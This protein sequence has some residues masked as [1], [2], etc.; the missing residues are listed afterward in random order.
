MASLLVELCSSHIE[1]M[2]IFGEGGFPLAM[3]K[4]SALNKYLFKSK[5]LASYAVLR[6]EKKLFTHKTISELL[7]K[8]F[9]VALMA[10]I[11]VSL[12]FLF[13]GCCVLHE[14]LSRI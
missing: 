10:L 8:S 6:K 7:M 9:N 3:T 13:E 14:Q 11:L 5:V 1:A 2:E 12:I 4:E